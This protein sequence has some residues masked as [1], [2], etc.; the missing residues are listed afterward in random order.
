MGTVMQAPQSSALCLDER[1]GLRERLRG[2]GHSRLLLQLH[3]QAS[4]LVQKQR[5][6][7]RGLLL[8]HLHDVGGV[9]LGQELVHLLLAVAG[10]LPDD[11]I[12]GL[13]VR[14]GAAHLEPEGGLDQG[15]GIARQHLL[16]IRDG[17]LR[18]GAEPH[19]YGAGGQDQ[20]LGDE[21]AE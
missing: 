3:L 21:D 18:A 2:D 12:A 10:G 16:R 19:R 5:A 11:E 15:A 9:I 4:E 6:P 1:G 20:V 14:T 13:D 17:E 8:R 7:Q